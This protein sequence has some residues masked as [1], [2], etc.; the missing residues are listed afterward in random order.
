[1]KKEKKSRKNIPTFDIKKGAFLLTQQRLSW[2]QRQNQ[3]QH[4]RAQCSVQRQMP[5]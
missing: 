2:L 3:Q 5:E 4:R 1:M